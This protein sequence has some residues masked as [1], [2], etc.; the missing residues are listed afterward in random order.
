MVLFV[1]MNLCCLREKR[2]TAIMISRGL[3]SGRSEGQ[4]PLDG[5]DGYDDCV[6]NRVE[7]EGRRSFGEGTSWLEAAE[8]PPDRLPSPTIL[9]VWPTLLPIVLIFR[10]EAHL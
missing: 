4:G 10:S 6:G 2:K 5:Y 1:R 9:G 8:E 7:V 3:D